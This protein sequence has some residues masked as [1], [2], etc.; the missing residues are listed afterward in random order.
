[1]DSDAELS[2]STSDSAITFTGK[3]SPSARN[4]TYSDDFNENFLRHII[5]TCRCAREYATAQKLRVSIKE[6]AGF[7][8]SQDFMVR[9]LKTVCLTLR[10]PNLFF[11]FS[12]CC[13]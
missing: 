1:M 2:V 12:T 6:A 13:M 8:S 7:E 5:V 4:M 11:N 9:M 3:A 10:L